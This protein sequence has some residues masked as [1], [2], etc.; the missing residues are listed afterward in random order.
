MK[1]QLMVDMQRQLD[2]SAL[3]ITELEQMVLRHDFKTNQLNDLLKET[4]L[5]LSNNLE[6]CLHISNLSKI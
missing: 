3:R 6:V 4:S 1:V 5:R 2:S